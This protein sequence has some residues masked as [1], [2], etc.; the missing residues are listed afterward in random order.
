M[1]Q[2]A[3]DQGNNILNQVDQLKLKREEEAR[4]EERET[5][6][7]TSQVH[8]LTLSNA[9]RVS[10]PL[11]QHEERQLLT[12]QRRPSGIQPRSTLL[13]RMALIQAESDR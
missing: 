13:E 10:N 2:K 4:I 3:R 6:L 5:Q 8:E 1:Q 12:P 11:S 9:R 7:L